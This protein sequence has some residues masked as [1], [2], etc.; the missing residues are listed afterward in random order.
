[1]GE[2]LYDTSAV[3]ELVARGRRILVDYVSILTV[4]EYPPAIRFAKTVLYPEKRDYIKAIEWQTK[5]RRQGSPVSAVDLIIAAQAYNH[6]LTLVTLDKHF[7]TIKNL[8]AKD[9]KLAVELP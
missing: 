9:L 8:V 2:A 7:I 6:N 5:L 3:I 1:V 4:V